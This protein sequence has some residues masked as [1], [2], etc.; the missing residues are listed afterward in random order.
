MLAYAVDTGVTWICH[1]G[2]AVCSQLS[3]HSHALAAP[4]EVV[5]IM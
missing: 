5:V 2:W 4:E 3:I 1:R